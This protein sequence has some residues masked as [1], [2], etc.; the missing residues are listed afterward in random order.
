[1]FPFFVNRL[2]LELSFILL[3][4]EMSSSLSCRIVMVVFIFLF[5]KF[6]SVLSSSESGAILFKLF[7][8][9]EEEDGPAGMDVKEE[10]WRPGIDVK[11]EDWPAGMDVKEEDWPAGMDVNEDCLLYTSDAADE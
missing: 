1:M 11:E 3:T 7:I 8:G 4:A 5:R 10:D 2:V 6:C 9:V